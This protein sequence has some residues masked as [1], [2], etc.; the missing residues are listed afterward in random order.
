MKAHKIFRKICKIPY[1]IKFGVIRYFNQRHRYDFPS[2]NNGWRKIGKTPVYG[3]SSTGTVFDPYVYIEENKY[4]MIVSCRKNDSIIRISSKDGVDWS[5]DFTILSGNRGEW[6][7]RVNRGC[8][9]Q[10][11]NKRYLW[12][13]GQK[14]GVSAIGLAISEDGIHFNRIN[15]S[16][17]IRANLSIEGR[18]T[19]NPCVIVDRGVLKMWYSAGENY[20]PDVICYAESFDGVN[21]EKR[22]NAVLTPNL[23]NEWEKY[24][25]GGCQV[26]KEKNIYTM[27]YI[28]YQNVD[29]ARICIAHSKDG[30][31]W[32]RSRNNLL[33]SP[34]KNTWDSD[35][36]YK[37][38]VVYR[39]E[40]LYM[41]YNGRKKH[42]EYIGMAK[43]QRI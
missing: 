10:F 11:K 32:N 6:D 21:W 24:K 7:E 2:E 13:T 31:N 14:N 30:I 4:V 38:T 25:I 39:G 43:K 22:E 41:W 15:G 33:L 40:W 29:V 42:K 5:E 35:A 26:I 3:D 34:S 16:P 36:C 18:S 12:Y 37:P 23:I 20:E 1:R 17:V 8:L 27:Y 9:L 28:G 19:M